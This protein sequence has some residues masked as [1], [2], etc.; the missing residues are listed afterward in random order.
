MNALHTPK[1]LATHGTPLMV[2][3]LPTT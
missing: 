3:A 1:L 2:G